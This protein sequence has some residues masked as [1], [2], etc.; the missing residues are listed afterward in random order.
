MDPLAVRVLFLAAT[1]PEAALVVP[2]QWH[3]ELWL[4]GKTVERARDNALRRAAGTDANAMDALPLLLGRGR[5]LNAADL[6]FLAQFRA[7]LETRV[8]GRHATGNSARV[9]NVAAARVSQRWA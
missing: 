3:Q 7:A 1:D 2:E 6:G 8:R 9:R 4:H 5:K